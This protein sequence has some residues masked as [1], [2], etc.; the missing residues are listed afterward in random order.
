[1]GPSPNLSWVA[2]LGGGR[3]TRRRAAAA[4]AAAVNRRASQGP[5]LQRSSVGI[6]PAFQAWQSSF[7][8]P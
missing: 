7:F 5:G 1:M 4:A 3:A 6:P 8:E 2:R